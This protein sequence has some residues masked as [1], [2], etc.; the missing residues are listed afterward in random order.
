MKLADYSLKNRA[1]L[2]ACVVLTA[3]GGMASYMNIGRL[4]DPE[5]S[6]KVAV[7]STQYPGATAEQVEEEVTEPLETALQQLKQ[8]YE[9]KSISRP[10]MSIIQAEMQD[11]YDKES[12]PQVWDEMR[13]KIGAAAKRLPPGASDPYINDD[14][15]DVYGIFFAL[16]GNGYSAHD[17]KEIAEDIR[18]ELMVCEDVG[19]IALS[20][21][22]QE[23][24]WLKMDQD[25][26]AMLGISPM[27]IVQTIQDQDSIISGGSLQMG[28]QEARIRISGTVDQVKSM[29]DLLISGRNSN[30]KVRVGDVCTVERGYMD[31]T[32]SQIY[33]DG[34]QAV[35]I[36][37]STV[38]GGNVIT[39]GNSVGEKL[40]EIN[41]KLP[42]GA[43]LQR[44]AYQSETVE[45]AVNGFVLNLIEAVAIVLLVLIL[46]MGW[47]EGI[48]IGIVLVITILGTFLVMDKMGV[49]LQRISL[50]ALII[51][52]GMLVDN[53]IVVVEGIMIG[54][55]RGKT[56][57]E[58]AIETVSETQ[59][60]LL[61]ATVIAIMAFAA[62]SLSKDVTGEF[63]KSLFQVIAISLGLSWIF[64]VTITPFLCLM[65]LKVNSEEAKADPY[66]SWFYRSYR[67][68]LGTSIRHRPTVIIGI[69]ALLGLSLWGFGFVSHSFFPNSSRPQ[70]TVSLFLPEGTHI[71][72]TTETVLVLEKEIREFEGVTHVGAFSGQ[73]ALRF[74]LT[75]SP[76][77]PSS[78]FADLIVS[79]DDYGRIPGLIE[80][81]RAYLNENLPEVI[82]T[83]EPFKLGPSSAAVEARIVGAD[84]TVLYR[85]AEQIRSIF[86]ENAN[87]ESIRSN[88]GNPI[89]SVEFEVAEARSR[90]TGVGRA[91]IARSIQMANTG[92]VAGVYR[93][94][95]DLL[96]IMIKT[97][98]DYR[99]GLDRVNEIQVW[100]SGFGTF[101]PIGQIVDEL[102]IVWE[103]P[104][105][106]RLDRKRTLT[107]SAKQIKGTSNS[108]FAQL[109]PKVEALELP[110]G[111]TIEWGG[112]YESSTEA[113]QKL[114][115][116]IP[117]AF[118]MMLLISIVLFNSFR[119]PLIIFIGLP[120]A[121]I[122]VTAGLLVSGQPFGFMATLGFLS[123]SGMLIKNE[124]V[125]LEQ[126]NIE[127]AGGSE[128]LKAVINAAVSRV[129]PVTMAALT[130][131]LGMIP[132][133]W[134]PFFAAMAVTIMAG[135]TFATVL[136]LVFVPVVYTLFFR[137]R[138]A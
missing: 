22:Q 48:I 120:L 41:S 122:G 94:G 112:E 135:L 45:K 86:R 89:K 19:R 85:I 39:M 110:E 5:F 136:T 130:T 51:A 54:V 96:P 9:I 119:H 67:K 109:R 101:L 38:E 128:P 106:H 2:W 12:L 47:R 8:L 52:L 88:W 113:N 72:Q 24:V 14:F 123:L 21:L 34:E 25:K 68:V 15:G 111:Y 114:G 73:G 17:L 75:Y 43:E 117:T 65:L 23:V 116:N 35:G 97:N 64:A 79:V 36:G 80:E 118:L 30:E 18:L 20:G 1:V 83:I 32:A 129:R 74:I 46:F 61:G 91:D 127:L 138:K 57:R 125:L 40:H 50:G 70:F 124:I 103:P 93:D 62:I 108:L 90:E 59:W 28:A 6:I 78:N 4:E 137:V 126:I 42:F 60:P 33:F 77:M 16:T 55:Q 131:V 98:F 31:P 95:N 11:Q 100:S 69:V 53:A 107:V 84:E 92:V 102:S 58:A 115:A 63:L 104:V 105:I 134:D 56:K 27:Q 132:L 87:A 3:L 66:D 29:N 82:H 37:I 121:L 49:L 81:T 71:N 26:L 44:I 76:E 13:R 99:D 10:G 7:I 133:L